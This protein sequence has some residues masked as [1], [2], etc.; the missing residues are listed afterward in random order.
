MP[1][2]LK[3]TGVLICEFLLLCSLQSSSGVIT[4]GTG[5]Y[6]TDNKCTWLIDGGSGLPVRLKFKEFATECSWDHLY[7]F[8]GNSVSAPLI[9]VLR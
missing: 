8:D 6:T 5:N 3:T 9:A 7:I 4:D 2:V 1:A